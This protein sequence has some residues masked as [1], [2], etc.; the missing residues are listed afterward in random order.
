[1]AHSEGVEPSSSARQADTLPLS[2]ECFG[3]G[4]ENRTLLASVGSWN[5]TTMLNPRREAA[6]RRVCALRAS[7][8]PS[9]SKR[10]TPEIGDDRRGDHE[11]PLAQGIMIVYM[12]RGGMEEFG[13][14][15]QSHKLKITGSNPVPASILRSSPMSGSAQGR[16]TTFLVRLIGR[17]PDFESGNPGSRPGPGSIRFSL[18]R[19]R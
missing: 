7:Q 6:M 2:Y 16:Q 17:T 11:K 19:K 10:R 9:P 4:S 5:I 1:M 13:R 15:R 3:R 12:R 18:C 8:R 14:P